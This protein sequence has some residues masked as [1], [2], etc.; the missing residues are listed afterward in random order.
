MTNIKNYIS[1]PFN[2]SP[3]LLQTGILPQPGSA[4]WNGTP[5]DGLRYWPV[6]SLA[7]GA[8]T[9]FVVSG[10]RI[11]C[12]AFVGTQYVKAG[13]FCDPNSLGN[14]TDE[15]PIQIVLP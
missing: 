4:N 3:C 6:P 9:N 15:R 12:G 14:T 2:S 1:P 7:P 13:F 5:L 10:Y 8:S 11:L